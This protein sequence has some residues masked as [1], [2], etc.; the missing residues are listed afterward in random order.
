MKSSFRK[1]LAESY[2]APIAIA[3]L[4]ARVLIG[5]IDG[6]A[7]PIGDGIVSAIVLVIDA[8]G[9]REMPY[10][11][12]RLDVFD[13]LLLSKGIGKIRGGG[14]LRN[15]CLVVSAECYVAGG[16]YGA[17]APHGWRCEGG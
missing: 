12:H 15:C 7:L 10:I 3:I 8:V 16:R 4:L 17:C 1:V 5:T 6:L 9:E 14:G 2:V 11:P 13:L